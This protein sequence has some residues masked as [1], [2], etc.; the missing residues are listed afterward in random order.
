MLRRSVKLQFSDLFRIAN[1]GA[2]VPDGPRG[3]V[4]RFAD[5]AGGSATGRATNGRPYQRNTVRTSASRAVSVLAVGRGHDP[6]VN[7]KNMERLVI[8]A[9]YNSEYSFASQN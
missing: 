3:R 9:I 8:P 2:G 7:L 4:Y 5:T 6:A 1:V